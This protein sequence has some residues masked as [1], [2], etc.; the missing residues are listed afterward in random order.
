MERK[1]L[2]KF[3]DGIRKAWGS[4]DSALISKAQVLME[5]L[6]NS[7]STGPWLSTFRDGVL[8]SRE[9]YRDPEHG[10]VLLAHT[11]PEDFYRRPHDHGD[12]WVIYAVHSGE[13]RMRTF[14]RIDLEGG[15][16][17]LSGSHT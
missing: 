17:R 5:E 14:D 2:T 6:A 12:A 1:S 3:I 15:R 13:M 7:P 16:A 4:H 8:D 10:F 11:E 9:L